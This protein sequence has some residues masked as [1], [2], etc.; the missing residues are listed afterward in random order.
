MLETT[1]LLGVGLIYKIAK[2][3]YPYLHKIQIP[4]QNK[5]VLITGCTDGIGK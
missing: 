5:Y 2:S 4:P 1:C 3:V